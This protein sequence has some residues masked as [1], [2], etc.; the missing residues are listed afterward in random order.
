[1]EWLLPAGAWAF[2]GIGVVVLLYL[3]RRKATRH[4][5][6][7]LL[8]WKKMEAA[9]EA[10]RPF[11]KL[12]KQWLL[13]LQLM[14][15]ALL[16]FALLR[17]ALP[18]GSQ[19]EMALLFDV[20]ASMQAVSGDKSRLEM[21]VQDA[22]ALVDGAKEGDAITVLTAGSTVGQALTRSTDKQKVRATLR[23]LKAEN[24]TA[25]MQGALSLARAMRR[26][27]PEM[28]IIVYSDSAISG[29]DAGDL[30]FRGVGSGADN[31]SILSLRCSSQ[32]EGL[33]AFARV[34]N[35]GAASDITVECYADGAL[36]DLRSLSLPQGGEE[37][38]QFQAPA[39]AQ[40][41]WVAIQEP[42][43]LAADNVRYWVAQPKRERNVLLVTQ[44]NVF[45]EKALA[46]R[47]DVKVVK[48]GDISAAGS[49]E[50][51]LVILDGQAPQELP[52]TGS[53][54]A[55]APGR[56]ILGI[57]PGEASQAAGTLR[58]PRSAL[59]ER[60]TQ[61]L[62][63]S[64]FSLRTFFP[65]AGGQSILL[66]GDSPLLSVA[67]QNGRRAA[68]LGFDL[69]DSNLPMK[70]DFPILMQNLLDYLLP[71]AVGAVEGATAG[72]P[73][74]L[75]LDERTKSARVITPSGQGIPVQ[76][77]VFTDTGE[78]GIYALQEDRM[79]DTRRTTPFVLHMAPSEADVRTVAAS[80]LAS[81]G[82][83]ARRQGAGREITVFFLL[84]AL[85]LLLVEWEV[86]RR[87]A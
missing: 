87:G 47:Q 68:V 2:L 62:L 8:L 28:S 37:S 16:A 10:S 45:V 42:D 71:E 29:E 74:T 66:W 26:D 12:R 15:A 1:M 63:L 41:V 21:A 18:G 84:A 46:L 19:G 9:Q 51:D 49:Q 70:P 72:E 6:P 30:E 34:A 56:E 54:L 14:L 77:G 78:I 81:Q 11:Q 79:D 82:E 40:S 52:Q 59:A 73:V 35:Y 3:L 76:G 39:G 5:V 23:E 75:A 67:D 36:C 4:E 60:L 69:H 24:G 27:L 53:L 33:A 13:L 80:N 38:L 17:P 64:E 86:S 58:A 55:L 43:A 25:D 20:S 65:L 32:E 7:S 57:A 61:N 83:M 50:Y 31:R 22:L 48:A 85:M 44:G